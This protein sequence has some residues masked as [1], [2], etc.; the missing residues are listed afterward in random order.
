MSQKMKNNISNTSK[1]RH[2]KYGANVVLLVVVAVVLAG[3]LAYLTNRYSR[4]ADWTIGSVNSLSPKTVKLVEFL[5]KKTDERVAKLT[6]AKKPVTELDQSYEI[7]SLFPRGTVDAD[8]RDRAQ[9]VDDLLGNYNRASKHVTLG[10]KEDLEVRIRNRYAQELEPYQK[11]VDQFEPLIKKVEVFFTKEAANFGA[12]SQQ[13]GLTAPEQKEILAVQGAFSTGIPEALAKTRQQIR[14]LT[15][16]TVPEWSQATARIKVLLDGIHEQLAQIG[17]ADPR[18]FSKPLQA[19]F[20]NQGPEYKKM[21]AE[22]AAYQ[23]EIAALKP[24][25]MDEILS[26]LTTGCVVILGPE[27]VKVV[28]QYEIF[29]PQRTGEDAANAPRYSFEGEQ[30]I[31]SALLAMAEPNKKKVVFV[32]PAPQQLTSGPFGSVAERLKAANFEVLEWAPAP[33][34]PRPDQGPSENPP[35]IG[36]GVVWIVFP[37]ELPSQQ[38]MMM[39]MPPA[40][41]RLLSEA[42]QRHMNEGG[43]ALFLAEAVSGPMAMFGG[44]SGYPF[45]RQVKPFGINVKAQYVVV[46]AYPAGDKLQTQPNLSLNKFP[47]HAITSPMQALETFFTA[48]KTPMGVVSAPTVVEVEA[49]KSADVVASVILQTEKSDT[50]WATANAEPQAKFDPKVDIASPVSLGVASENKKTGQKVVVIGNKLFALSDLV[51]AQRLEMRNGMPVVISVLP[52][53]GE[54]FVNS[55]YW[56]S[57]YENMIAISPQATIALRIRSMKSTEE[58]LVRGGA[59]VVPPLLAVAL[60]AVVFYMRRR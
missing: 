39:G 35:A 24:L 15:D 51:D 2:W 55:V 31:T 34:G 58:I 20:K 37:A 3:L 30:A 32:S 18:A 13:A 1:T 26:S 25:K 16:S 45:A 56:L 14:K 42:L 4:R 17:E 59:F 6:A 8:G 12:L 22:I 40:D 52:G 10:V 43:N 29:K 50:I 54:L 46:K 57:D 38:Q 49:A 28:D 44:A 53:N 27:G 23:A 48:R 9:Q 47:E 41:P 19:Y 33:V 11:A 5:D 21:A 7:V 36:K 60:G